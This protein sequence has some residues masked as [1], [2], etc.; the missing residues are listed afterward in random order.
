MSELIHLKKC[1]WGG[2]EE[3]F[4]T[5]YLNKRYCKKHKTMRTIILYEK[6]NKNLN[7]K[8][9]ITRQMIKKPCPECGSKLP[10]Y[11]VRYCSD[12]CY[13][14]HDKKHVSIYNVKGWIVHHKKRIKILEKKLK[15]L[16]NE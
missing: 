2:C 16:E 12:I 9:K 3:T 4:E 7:A 6:N 10:P 5:K 8:V 1:V 11:R 15:V 13:K 14:I